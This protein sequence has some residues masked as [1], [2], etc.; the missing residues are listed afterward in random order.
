MSEP[1][2]NRQARRRKPGELP[3][4]AGA[5]RKEARRSAG[6]EEFPTHESHGMV[7]ISR[8]SGRVP[9]HGSPVEP[10]N[11][12]RLTVQEGVHNHGLGRD[13]WYAG[14]MVLQLHMSETQFAQMVTTPN[15]GDGVPCTLTYRHTEG[16]VKLDDPPAEESAAGITRRQFREDVEDTLATM[17]DARRRVE[18]QLDAAKISGK[19]RESLR[20]EIFEVFRVFDDYAPFAMKAFEENV[21]TAVAA[22]K[23]EVA[24]YVSHVAQQTGLAALQAGADPVLTL[25]DVSEQDTQTIDEREIE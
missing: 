21:Q 1:S 15:M 20:R 2:K 22:A 9:L 16:F 6:G 25:A 5:A 11:F 24:T 7:G 17:D 3:M 10:Y 14:R 23:T 13:H 8:C 19:L 18:E 4:A 12:I